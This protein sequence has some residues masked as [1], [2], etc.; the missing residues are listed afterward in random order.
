V[1]SLRPRLARCALVAAAISCAGASAAP[2]ADPAPASAGSPAAARLARGSHQAAGPRFTFSAGRLGPATRKRVRGSSWRPGCPVGLDDLRLLRIGYWGFDGR[3]RVGRMI[4]AATAVRA[5]HGA[6][7]RLFE[8]RFPIRRMR[9]VDDYGASDSASIAADN[10]SAFNCRL[11]TG[12]SRFSEH[13][14]GRAVDI[15]PIENP[16]VYPNGTTVHA[17]SRPY[18]DRSRHRPGMAFRGGVLVRAFAA[19]GWGWGGDWRPPSATDYQHFS[20]TGR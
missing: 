5:I 12:S 9:L 16:Y 20:S 8:A 19:V 17:A 18:L 6:F 11:A 13:A 4:V 1:P 3:A 7:A 15:D 14:Y 10:T 2:R